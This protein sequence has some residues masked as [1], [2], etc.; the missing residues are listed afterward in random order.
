MQQPKLW[1]ASFVKISFSS[2]FVFLT[3]YILATAMSLY[4]TEELSGTDS[5]AGL[6][7][8]IFII[9]AVILRLFAGPFMLQYGVKKVV[10]AALL[11]Y[12]IF[13][14]SYFAIF[15][16]TLLLVIRFLHG[17]SFAVATTSTNT[18]ALTFIPEER[19]G[20]GISYFSLFM[21]MAMVIGPYIGLT[22]MHE[23]GFLAVFI[24]CAVCAMLSYILGVSAYR[25]SRSE[26]THKEQT[27]DKPSAAAK[28]DKKKMSIHH[29]IE[30]NAVPI[31]ISGFIIALAYSG[32][33]TF[34]SIYAKERGL[35]DVASYYFVFFGL[36]I[37]LP[38]PF[39][40]KIMDK[41]NK[42]FIVYPSIVIFAIGMVLLSMADTAAM[43]LVS[44]AVAGLGYG[45]IL[46]C[47][48]TIAIMSAKPERRGLATATFYLLFD[49]G[50]GIGSYTLGAIAASFSYSM[51]YII[52]AAIIM[53][54]SIFYYILY[55]KRELNTAPKYK[56][57]M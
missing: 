25:N 8:A 55:H 15:S 11:F 18:A 46:P 44:G 41:Y 39:I 6:A 33:I 23:W 31:S 40:G 38:R 1:T 16:F 3:F 35:T 22:I 37:I 43:L 50:Y 14:I 27:M 56:Q 24:V 19:K 54:S 28:T 42:S 2:F 52:C 7:M 49:L 9:A 32:L 10:F 57:A 30:K 48:Q 13:S 12:F 45:A 34:I 47:L 26:Q 36:M 20:E 21:S 51:V 17:G 53:I 29:F 5:Q 4:V